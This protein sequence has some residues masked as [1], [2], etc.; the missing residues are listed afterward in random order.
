MTMKRAMI[1]AALMGTGTALLL[2]RG[3]VS[4]RLERAHEVQ[5]AALPA[6][7]V[8]SPWS[9]APSAPP[10]RTPASAGR[11]ATEL[12]MGV[13]GAWVGGYLGYRIAERAADDYTVKGDAGYSPA[14]NVGYAVGSASG[15]AL[16]VYAAGCSGPARGSL[17][18]TFAAAGTASLLLL[19]LIDDPYM[20]LFGFV[21]VA[22]LQAVAAT[23]GFNLSRQ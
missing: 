3:A 8:I 11:I 10:Q 1:V 7:G 4:Q 13:G 22:P 15:S 17:P 2:P 21:I 9:P 18:A 20:P 14:G 12:L 16:A 5:G 23:A 19:L 6:G